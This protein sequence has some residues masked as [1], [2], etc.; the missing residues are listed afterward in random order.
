[1]L[2]N[3]V[4]TVNQPVADPLQDRLRAG[5]TSVRLRGALLHQVATTSLYQ[6]RQLACSR[7]AARFA[8]SVRSSPPT[9]SGFGP[10]RTLSYDSGAENSPFGFE[11]GLSIPSITRK[12]EKACRNTATLRNPMSLSSP[13]RKIW[14]QSSK[15]MPPARCVLRSRRNYYKG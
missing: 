2:G 13:A 14:Y 7:A 10:Q 5:R 1:M 12:T 15:R 11:R 4:T 8:A 9:R 6:L 3:R